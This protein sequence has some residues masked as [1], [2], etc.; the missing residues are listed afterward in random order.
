MNNPLYIHLLLGPLIV[1]IAFLFKRFPPRRINHLYGYRTPR[2]MRN[3]EAWDC[4]NTYS[5]NAIFIVALLTCVVQVI[6]YALLDYKNSMLVSCGFLVL[7]LV[8]VIPL[9]ES[10]LKN[11]GH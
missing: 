7:G 6:S 9:T 1:I 4:A 11:R 8:A 2:S 3:Q 5:S 10:H